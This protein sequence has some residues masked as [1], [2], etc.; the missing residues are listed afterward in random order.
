MP[1][2]N[3]TQPYDPVVAV[4]NRQLASGLWDTPDS[5]DTEHVRHARATAAALL[6]LL[7][8]GVTTTHALHGG[9]VK[10]A[11]QALLTLSGELT[12]NHPHVAELALGVAWLVTTGRRTRAAIE[13]RVS[14]DQ[15]FAALHSLFSDEQRVRAYVEQITA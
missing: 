15:T 1:T 3:D 10:K 12:A 9:Q 8:A 2:A 13:A 6:A 11:V 4:L 14:A 7:R 5:D